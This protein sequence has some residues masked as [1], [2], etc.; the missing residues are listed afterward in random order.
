MIIDDADIAATVTNT[1]D[2]I[3]TVTWINLGDY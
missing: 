3:V 1:V 2:A